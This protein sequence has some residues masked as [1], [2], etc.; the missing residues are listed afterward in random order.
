GKAHITHVI[1][2]AHLRHH[3][4]T[5]P[6]RGQFAVADHSHLMHHRAHRSLE[7]LF[8]HRTLVQRALH[9]L[10]Q[11]VH[12]ERLAPPVA[13]HERGQ[14][15]FRR[16]GRV[17]ALAALA[18]LAP[19]TNRA[20]ILADAGINDAGVFVLAEGA[21]HQARTLIRTRDTC[22]TAPSPRHA[23]AR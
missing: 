17:E 20:A 6:A 7:L 19:A 9:R 13:L 2:L 12:V 3:E 18:A 23:P 4:I 11:L 10:P 8:G 1:E 21:V 14:L 16:L 15:E 5:E 22:G